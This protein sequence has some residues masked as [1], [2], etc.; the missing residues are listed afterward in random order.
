MNRTS[1]KTSSLRMLILACL[2]ASVAM[3]LAQP[4]GQPPQPQIPDGGTVLRDVPY[5][6]GGH[7]RQ[8]LDLYLPKDGTNLPLI[9]NT[10]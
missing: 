4:A 1:I 6:P 2:A 7:E 10:P 5:V 9:I 3:A 8:K